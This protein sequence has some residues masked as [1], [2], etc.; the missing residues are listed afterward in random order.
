MIY[1]RFPIWKITTS[2]GLEDT[3][4][5]DP[6]SYLFTLSHEMERTTKKAR[7]ELKNAN[8]D[9]ILQSIKLVSLLL[10]ATMT[11]MGNK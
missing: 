7:S 9:V 10:I 2:T 3:Q 1:G 6:F 11:V 4:K 8:N 5:E